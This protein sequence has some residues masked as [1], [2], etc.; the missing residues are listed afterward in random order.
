MKSASNIVR[1]RKDQSG[2]RNARERE[3]LPAALE[4][5]ETPPSPIGRTIGFLIMAIFAVAL[6]WACF[7]KI[8]IV[9]TAP[10]KIIPT[11]R[12]KTIQP[13]EIGVINAIHVRD[14][15]SVREGDPLIE[16]D[17][18]INRAERERLQNDLTA[19]RLDAARLRAALAS[20]TDPLPQFQPPE[21]AAEALLK[22]QR[23]FLLD[24]TAEHRAKL[25]ALESQKR[26]KEAE[27]A[28]I[29]AAIK[30]LEGMIPL[31]RERVDMRKILLEKQNVSRIVYLENLQSLA[32]YEGEL[33][34]QK[35][36]LSEA[37]AA[38]ESL[39][40]SRAATEKEFRRALSSELVEAE[41]KAASL[42]YEV[43]KIA[44][45]TKLQVLTAPVDGVVQQLAVNTI[46]GVV[47]PAQVLLMVV[48][49]SMN[50]EIEA[51]V[52]NRDIGFIHAGQEAEIKVDT[53]NFTRYGLV[54]GKVLSIS[55]DAVQRENP[56]DHQADRN[57]GSSEPPGQELVYHARVSLDRTQ[58]RIEENMINLSPG[59]AVTV[60]IKT[61][62]RRVIGYLFS[63]LLRYAHDS[64]RER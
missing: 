4:I 22:V 5:A 50:I 17:P 13:F 58:M 32:D 33:G 31:V 37:K 56:R 60:E 51:T 45:R 29:E 11:G 47:T 48:P 6:I 40:E 62:T 43:E 42:S 36:R 20:A 61:G 52:S 54:H 46:G 35:S 3:F 34:V 1:L 30:R 57:T 7:G 27:Y 64:L 23:Q 15:Q 9:A 16:L 55:R 19:A 8:D 53:F 44:T 41:R 39:T 21:D 26:Q 63:P 14:G 25:A 10:G 28:S 2:S 18:A 49:S 12:T 59:M 24:Q 38:I